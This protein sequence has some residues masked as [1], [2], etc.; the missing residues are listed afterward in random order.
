MNDDGMV[1]MSFNTS[2]DEAQLHHVQ[3]FHYEGKQKE[4]IVS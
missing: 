1:D 4:S 2:F 3:Y